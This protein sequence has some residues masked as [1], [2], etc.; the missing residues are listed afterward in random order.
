MAVAERQIEAQKELGR[1]LRKYAGRWVAVC[2]AKV[3]GQARTPEKLIERT[4]EKKV[5]RIFRVPST[6]GSALL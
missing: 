6:K 3:V 1:E 5:D 4:R 2:G